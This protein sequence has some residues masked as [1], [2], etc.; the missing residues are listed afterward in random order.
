MSTWL[1]EQVIW[2][3]LCI[4][5][6]PLTLFFSFL[7]LG[8]VKITPAHDPN[9]Y[10]LGKR[11]NLAMLTIF[12]DDGIIIG[13]CGKFTGMK[14]FE[15]RK[16]VIQELEQ[17]GLYRGTAENPMVVPVCSR[18]KDIVE[19]MIKPQWYVKC[20]QMAADAAEAVRC[21]K[22]KV[23]PEMHQKT[24]FNWMDNIRD[25]CISRQLWWG[26]RIP[27]YFVTIDDTSAKVGDEADNEFWV[28]GRSEAEARTNAAKRF[29]VPEEKI[30]L[31]QDEDV[32]DTW[33]SSALFPFSVFGWPDKVCNFTRFNLLYALCY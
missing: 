21:G 11:H 25:W 31:K 20:D 19:P 1:S 12:S 30:I 23:V 32:L 26:H 3:Q 14:R 4:E 5:I 15:A 17:I 16:A 22:L 33:F 2:P 13:D 9:D 18:S 27:A 29:N 6:T 10:D 8:A 7:F 28:S 24:W